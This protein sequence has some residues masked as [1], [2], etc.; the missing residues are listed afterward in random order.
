MELMPCQF[1]LSKIKHKEK[2]MNVIKGVHS[3][4]TGN[5]NGRGL[6]KD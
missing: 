2:N 4:I 6:K 1:K 3:R 5:K